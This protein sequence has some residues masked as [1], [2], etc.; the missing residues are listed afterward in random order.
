MQEGIGWAN[1]DGKRT[2]RLEH[3][4][5]QARGS[6]YV[7][8]NL[9]SATGPFKRLQA[10]VAPTGRDRLGYPYW[11]DRDL[12]AVLRTIGDTYS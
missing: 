1:V 10:Q 4:S 8:D 11:K 5:E 6:L 2:C 12:T 9:L 3:P 7:A